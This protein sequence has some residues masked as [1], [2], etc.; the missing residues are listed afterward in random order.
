M[1]WQRIA[2]IVRAD[3]LVRF[4]RVSTVVVFLLFS[5]L[6]YM[7]VPDPANGKALMQLQGRRV[8]YNSAAIGLGTASLAMIFIG[9]F[10]FYVISNA[11]RHDI[12]SRC[13]YIIA[14][15]RAGSLEYLLGKFFGN[16][17]FLTTFVSGFMLTSMA[18]VIV[19]G[20]APLEP[21]VFIGQYLL[22]LPPVIVF[23]SV[24]AIVFESVPWLSGR[25][26]DVIFFFVWVGALGGVTAMV[27][28]NT[29]RDIARYLDFSGFSY[30]IEN[31]RA[32]TGSDNLA[33]GSHRFDAAKPLFVFDGLLYS[34]EWLLPRIGATL[35]PLPLLLVAR[36]FFHRFDPARVRVKSTRSRV[37]VFGLVNRL[38][39]PVTG[40]LFALA[41]QG[42]GGVVSLAMTDALMT[43][44]SLPVAI[45]AI[46]GCALATVMT[47]EKK[48]LHGVLPIAFA[49]LALVI[50]DISS[51]EKRSGTLGLVYAAPLLKVRFVVWKFLSAALLAVAFLAVPAMRLAVLR[52]QVMPAFAIGAI[53]LAATATMLGIV[54]SNP[55]TFVVAFLSFWYVMINDPGAKP[56][57]DFAGFYGAATLPVTISYAVAALA[58]LAIA[59]GWHRYEL[60]RRW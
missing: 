21:L 31:L 52:P 58:L 11:L 45:A 2:A 43:L 27:E 33:I 28:T 25:L 16:V 49:A 37:D 5:A 4:R 13:G 19:R 29:G 59:E 60:Q 18:M 30:M 9:L 26:G 55:K 39:R 47:A 54:S 50:A 53:F 36:L 22:L 41:P 14:S 32:S 46:G 17:L 8:L 51:R 57:L 38:F 3:F 12:R 23:V 7:W 6:A 10:G 20:E 40:A 42:R 44:S 34:R 15:T 48:F 1:S 24:A 35:I 56:A